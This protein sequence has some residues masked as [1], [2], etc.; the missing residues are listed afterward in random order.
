MYLTSRFTAMRA[1]H[2]QD[3]RVWDGML[4]LQT[5]MGQHTKGAADKGVRQANLEL[6]LELSIKYRPKLPRVLS[7]NTDSTR[8]EVKQGLVVFAQLSVLVK[9]LIAYLEWSWGF[10]VTAGFFVQRIWIWC[11]TASHPLL[12][13]LHPGICGL[14]CCRVLQYPWWISRQPK[15]GVWTTE[16]PLFH[17]LLWKVS[18]KSIIA[19]RQCF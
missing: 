9:L 6:C 10:L 8:V 19:V 4:C 17:R 15:L 5:D 2:C 3:R 7:S 14:K 16:L 12:V 13:S 11:R 1:L 18:V